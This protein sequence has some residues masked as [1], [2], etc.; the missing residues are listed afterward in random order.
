[1]DFVAL[2]ASGVEGREKRGRSEAEQYDFS[3]DFAVFVEHFQP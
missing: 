1:M 3:A 2:F